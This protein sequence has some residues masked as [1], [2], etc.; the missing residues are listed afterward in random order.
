LKNDFCHTDCE[1][2]AL[3]TLDDGQAFE[4]LYH[5]YWHQLYDA[6]YQRLRNVQQA[7]DIVQDIFVTIWTRRAKQRIENLPA[8]LHT[9]VRF[10]VFNYVERDLANKAFF[11][12]FGTVVDCQSAADE[13]LMSKEMIKLIRLYARTLPEKRRQIFLLHLSDSLTTREIAEQLHIK[14]K[15]VQNQLGKVLHGLRSQIAHLGILFFFIY[16]C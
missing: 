15:T 4:V 2:L 12:P 10:R 5:R 1:L 3:L 11:E 8:Y 16:F 14:Q 7:E 9:A 13:Q 6:A